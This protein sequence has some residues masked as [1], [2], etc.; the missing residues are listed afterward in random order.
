MADK[1][2]ARA[3]D[4]TSGHGPYAPRANKGEGPGASSDVKINNK[5][6][7]RKG[8]E[9]L[10]HNPPPNNQ[11]AAGTDYVQKTEE[12]SASVFINNLPAAR[13]GDAVD[14]DGDKIAGGSPDVFIG[15]ALPFSVPPVV[16]APAAQAAIDKKT[17][18]YVANPSKYKVSSNDQVKGNYAG[19]PSQPADAGQSLIDTTSVTAG[20]IIP[21]LT[22][23]LTEASKGTWDETGMGGKPSNP[24]IIRIWKELGYPQSGAWINDQTAWCMGFVNYVLKNTGHRFVQTAGAKDI[25]NRAAA[26]KVTQIPLNQGQPG[27]IC[28]WSYSHVNFIYSNTGGKYVFVGGNQSTKAKNANNP[29]GG[30]VTKSWPSGYKAPGDGSLVSIWRPSKA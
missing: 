13:I 20:D 2:A 28:L 22:Q 27:D 6:A 10:P 5:G 26:Y 3:G 14:K 7:N 24:N 17:A 19:T 25:A 29:S 4:K 16:I 15:D 9:W 18:A 12:G 21:F 8:D 1:P 30:S 11:H 23:I